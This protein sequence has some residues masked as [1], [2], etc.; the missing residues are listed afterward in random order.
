MRPRGSHRPHGPA[1]GAVAAIALVAALAVPCVARAAEVVPLA[2]TS[3]TVHP[4]LALVMLEHGWVRT[5]GDDV[6]WAAPDHDDAAWEP[7]PLVP[8]IIDMQLLGAHDVAWFRLHVD[9]PAHLAADEL[10]LFLTWSADVELFLDGR[11]LGRFGARGAATDPATV[12]F[13]GRHVPLRFETPGRHVFAVRLDPRREGISRWM[14]PRP[15]FGLSITNAEGLAEHQRGRRQVERICYSFAAAALALGALHLFLFLFRREQ[16]VHLYYAASSFAVAT[17][18][19]TSYGTSGIE[20]LGGA[21]TFV[22]VNRVAILAMSVTGLLFYYSA[23][24]YPLPRYF[25]IFFAVS[26]GFAISAPF[27]SIAWIMVFTVAALTEQLR[28]LVHA[29]LRRIDGAWIVLIGGGASIFSALVQVASI[30]RI[31]P[32][33]WVPPFFYLYGFLALLLSMSIYLARDVAGIQRS[34][35][36][37]L[38]RV[39]ELSELAVAQ[40]RRAQEEQTARLL[41]EA[42]NLRQEDLLEEAK[43]RDRVLLQLSNA[44]DELAKAHEELRQTQSKLAQSER[45]ASLGQLVA[46]IAHEINTPVGAMASAQDSLRRA[47]AKLKEALTAEV[48]D[49][50]KLARLLS[51]IDDANRVME[52]GST[53]VT[54]IVRRLK[55]FARLDEAELKRVDLHEGLDDTLMLLDHELRGRVE[56][57]REYGQ[58]PLV[59]CYPGQINQVFLNLI[60]NARQAIPA[61]GHITITTWAEPGRVKVRVRD[62][63][64]GIPPE[65]LRKIFDPGFTTKGV[66]VGTGLGLAICYRIIEEH[67]GEITVESKPG[68]GSAFTVAIPLDLDDILAERR[69]T[70]LTIPPP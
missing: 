15:A 29:N 58:L 16:R 9:V 11:T 47:T 37:Q 12:S 39:Q 14:D 68:E 5:F 4:A 50:A 6:R 32:G 70:G 2:I 24:K 21:I 63:G 48:R 46:G 67:Q 52:S 23:F 35:A 66:R 51:V 55:T 10:Q 33:E 38:Q 49:D 8:G 26:L 64:V 57:T 19:L 1:R 60:H 22:Y 31:I 45:M 17:V 53:R 65:N 44:H 13:A 3:T 42:D 34:L 30:L 56:V 61:R 36:A 41:L 54:N 43:K 28:V 7:A 27:I 25:W 62:D 40:E 69:K 20:T 18:A 59:A